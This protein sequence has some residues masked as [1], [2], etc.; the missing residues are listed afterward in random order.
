MTLTEIS[1]AKNSLVRFKSGR[2][3]SRHWMA[4]KLI[5]SQGAKAIVH[6]L[7][8]RSCASVLVEPERV[9]IWKKGN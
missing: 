5:G 8:H 4:G 6:P 9:K 2:G 1:I 7:G 3:S